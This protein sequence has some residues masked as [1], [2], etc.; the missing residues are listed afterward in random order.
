MTLPNGNQ[1]QNQDPIPGQTSGTGAV[2]DT[3]GPDTGASVPLPTTR[4]MGAS[5]GR[6][7]TADDR[8]T[9]DV[10]AGVFPEDVDVS[11]AT[12]DD[13][14]DLVID[15][16]RVSVIERVVLD[17]KRPGG[18]EFAGIFAGRPRL[19]I[20][21]THEDLRGSV[22]GDVSIHGR[23]RPSDP[24]QEIPCVNDRERQVVTAEL[25]HFS[26]Y[27]ANVAA[28]QS[29]VPTIDA[30]Q[31]NLQTGA[32]SVSIP[33]KLPPGTNGLTPKLA[34]SFSSAGAN[35]IIS[36]YHS[37][38]EKAQGSWVGMGWSLDVG[39]IELTDPDSSKVRG[40]LVLNGRSRQLIHTSNDQFKTQQE[41]FLK[42]D[43]VDGATTHGDYFMVK[44][45]DGTK[46]R[47]GYETANPAYSGSSN[48]YRESGSRQDGYSESS[49]EYCSR[50][51]KTWKPLEFRYN[52]DQIK[53]TSGN[54][55]EITY[56]ADEGTRT[57]SRNCADA[58]VHYDKAVYPN[59]IHYSLNDAGGYKRKV[60]FVTSDPTT[61][62][63][64]DVPDNVWYNETR[65]LE[66]IETYVADAAGTWS[67][68]RK[69]VFDYEYVTYAAE[70]NKKFLLLKKVAEYDGTG[71]ALPS[72]SFDYTP[73]TGTSQ[74]E[75]WTNRTSQRCPIPLLTR[76]DNG[77]GGAVEYNY[78]AYDWAGNGG[79]SSKRTRQWVVNTKTTSDGMGN[80]FVTT[81][82]RSAP[83]P[84]GNH[85]AGFTTK[86]TSNY[87]PVFR[88]F[89]IVEVVGPS[90]H[91]HEHRFFRGL[92]DGDGRNNVNVQGY[93]GLT[94]LLDEEQYKGHGV[95]G[96]VQ[97]GRRR[98]RH[99]PDRK[100]LDRVRDQG[101]SLES[102]A[103]RSLLQR[104]ARLARLRGPP[105][106]AGDPSRLGL[107]Q[108]RVHPRLIRQLDQYE[109]V[110]ERLRR[111]L[112]PPHQ[113]GVPPP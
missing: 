70:S 29:I 97:E 49:S 62:A 22:S 73:Q 64:E 3:G 112:V 53:D 101:Q 60:V 100:A 36:E 85:V 34:L 83:S 86:L 61:N 59:E 99:R 108:D 41:S 11:V 39:H 1:N 30:N 65:R 12:V 15:D 92:D 42:V 89:G 50:G 104:Q 77:Y 94:S 19:T 17:A 24:W 13:R 68:A 90:G 69:Y 103:V 111:Q 27:L 88:G 33:I 8:V 93:D 113:A 18:Q 91:R 87:Y 37:S 10:Q 81:F 106:E 28:D 4:R 102:P 74:Y 84:T 6:V 57:V 14:E 63:R 95:R 67:L 51:G 43:K 47:F 5:G 96:R 16:K 55:V 79:S 109:G 107:D 46:F 2:G 76:V 98:V 48:F 32:S 52:L 21:Y 80:S 66:R 35:G 20:G 25:E 40:G 110:R 31:S 54:T 56:Q 38:Y 45:K 44:A 105:E 23:R 7:G 75:G 9:L 78:S 58:T 82:N 71:N 72:T 26:E